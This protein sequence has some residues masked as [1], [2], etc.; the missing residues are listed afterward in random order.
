M[1]PVRVLPPVTRPRG[2]KRLKRSNRLV[3]LVGIFLAIVAFVLIAILL[4]GQPTKTNGPT[5]PPTTVAIVAPAQ[6]IDL[7]APIQGTDLTTKDFPV[8]GAP[9]DGYTD[10]S[11]VIG[12]IARAP[13]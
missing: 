9:A 12:K 3:L 8:T 7:G 2:D 10:T 13:V 6:D 1:R 11:L 5:P 4:G